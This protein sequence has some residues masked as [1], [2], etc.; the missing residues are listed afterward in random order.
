MHPITRSHP[1]GPQAGCSEAIAD[2]SGHLKSQRLSDF[3]FDPCRPV[4]DITVPE[5]DGADAMQ[6]EEVSIARP[7]EQLIVFRPVLF[8][9]QFVRRHELVSEHER[10][11]DEDLVLPDE[12]DAEIAQHAADHAFVF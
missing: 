7:V 9:S 6:A 11:G 12:M 8:D 2:T 5:P 1:G 3:R 4:L 10:A